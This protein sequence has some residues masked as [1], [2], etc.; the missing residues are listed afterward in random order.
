MSDIVVTVPKT[1][2]YG[3]DELPLGLAQWCAEGDCAGDAWSGELWGFSVAG[4]RP[5]IRPGERVYIV[6]QDRL[7][8]YAPLVR[9]DQ[10]GPRY[11]DLIRGG[12]AVAVTIQ[13]PVRG[14]RG[15]RYRWWNTAAE[16][17][18]PDWRV[19]PDRTLERPAGLPL[20]ERR[21]GQ[22]SLF[23]EPAP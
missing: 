10:L 21:A 22:A 6:C 18:F 2:N 16:V 14:F 5:E 9:M 7:R 20:A 19:I 15:W 17:P 11:W 12:G 4:P 23:A 8:G 13:E 3:E 1:F